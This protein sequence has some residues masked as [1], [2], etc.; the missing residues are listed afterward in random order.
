MKGK[1]K[2]EETRKKLSE[3]L[4]NYYKNNFHCLKGVKRNIKYKKK[5][6]LK[7]C[8]EEKQVLE[9]RK[10]LLL[11]TPLK[12]IALDYN[13][14]KGVIQCIKE[15]RT[16][17]HIGE[18]KI[19]GKVNDIDDEKLKLLYEDFNNNLSIK[20]IMKKFKIS[21]STVYKYKKQWKL[22]LNL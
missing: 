9:I 8:L 22:H 21:M 13:V 2:S 12:E 18:F 3:S 7:H 4:N 20:D 16:W 14:S 17:Q 1:I 5:T 11:K 6:K 15:G 10:K 19:K